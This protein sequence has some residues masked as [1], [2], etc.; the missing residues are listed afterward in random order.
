MK[1]TCGSTGSINADVDCKSVEASNYG[2]CG[3]TIKGRAD[4]H[5]IQSN[6]WVGK[7]DVSNLGK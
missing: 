5:K 3:I 1:L 7:I 2:P 4:V 6:T